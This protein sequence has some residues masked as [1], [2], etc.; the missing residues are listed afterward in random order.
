MAE[1]FAAQTPEPLAAATEMALTHGP[2]PANARGVTE[3]ALIRGG[4]DNAS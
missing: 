1:G 3:A 2:S 4:G